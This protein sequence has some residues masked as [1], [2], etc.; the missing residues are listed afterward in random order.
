MSKYLSVLI[1]LNM[2]MQVNSM[3]ILQQIGAKMTQFSANNCL[4]I[5]TNGILPYLE[6]I[7]NTTVVLASFNTI[8]ENSYCIENR[9]MI[10]DNW[11]ST[12]L[13][14]QNQEKLFKSGSYHAVIFKKTMSDEE[15]K[16]F[17]AML[18]N[19]TK[20]ILATPLSQ[21][22]TKNYAIYGIDNLAPERQIFLDIWLDERQDFVLRGARLF[23]E[24]VTD[25][26]RRT[27]TVSVFDYAPFTTVFTGSQVFNGIEVYFLFLV[28]LKV[29]TFGTP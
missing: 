4:N 25:F 6:E 28:T 24:E 12:V 21:N 29:R 17:M 27:I 26:Q 8:I 5:K 13:F 10:I 22:D 16:Q 1:A 20:V 14:E 7:N 3:E 23:A 2:I 18:A 11:K 9:I 19:Y 15:R